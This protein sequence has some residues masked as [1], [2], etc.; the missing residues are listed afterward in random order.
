MGSL[1]GGP[2]Q[3]FTYLPGAR[4]PDAS[5]GFCFPSL[6]PSTV[7]MLGKGTLMLSSFPR[8][9]LCVLGL[10]SAM[11]AHSTSSSPK[12]RHS[13]GVNLSSG[14]TGVSFLLLWPGGKASEG[15][16]FLPPQFTLPSLEGHAEPVP[17]FST[18]R[19]PVLCQVL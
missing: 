15:P 18:C 10:S 2:T 16:S 5:A 11:E 14:L 7:R 3:A 4:V 1:G 13:R 8:E 12:K 19:V 17:S 9:R 6:T